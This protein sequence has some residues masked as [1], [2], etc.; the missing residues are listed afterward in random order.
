[1]KLKPGMTANV[2]V[3]IARQEDV[4]RVPS[5]ALR[6]NPS[7]SASRPSQAREGGAQVW[8]LRDAQLQ[9]VHVRPGLSDGTTTA[10]ASDELHENLR[11]VTGSAAGN[12]ESAGA[13]ANQSPLVPFGGRGRGGRGNS[14]GGRR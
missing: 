9:P 10:V 1:L 12:S 4:L 11:V 14:S 2:T 13:P 5:A 6:F 7:G 8:V 3:E